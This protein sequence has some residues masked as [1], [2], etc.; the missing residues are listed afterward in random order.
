MV[1]VKQVHV[2]N[3]G[4]S[5]FGDGRIIPWVFYISFFVTSL[6]EIASFGKAK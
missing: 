4:K 3:D 6:V 5:S 1:N 2:N